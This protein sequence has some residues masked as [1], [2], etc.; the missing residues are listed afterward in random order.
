[1]KGGD[2]FMGRGEIEGKARQLLRSLDIQKEV[3]VGAVLRQ[4]L[5]HGAGQY[6]SGRTIVGCLFLRDYQEPLSSKY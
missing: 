4:R 3:V 6:R 1:M 2:K 5:T